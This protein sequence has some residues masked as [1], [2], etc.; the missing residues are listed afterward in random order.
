MLLLLC[1]PINKMRYIICWGENI[2]E[3]LIIIR[4]DIVIIFYFIKG[5]KWKTFPSSDWHVC[6]LFVILCLFHKVNRDIKGNDTII[7]IILC[8]NVI[9]EV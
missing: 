3:K 7:Q 1:M 8:Y 9:K 4:G 2:K 6:V 5:K